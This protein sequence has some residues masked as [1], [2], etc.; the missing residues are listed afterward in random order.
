M[1]LSQPDG[2]GAVVITSVTIDESGIAYNFEGPIE[3]YGT[4]YST[5]YWEA[6]D[7][8]ETR[9]TM[10]GEARIVGNDGTLISSPL[11]GTF[12]RD[13]AKAELFFT[14]CVSNGDM[15]FVRWEVDFITKQVSVVYF[16]LND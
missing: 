7:E 3:G 1:D 15:N 8:E 16:S 4:V 2:T 14:D 13:G 12:R 5:Q 11:R 10:E 9:G 6:V